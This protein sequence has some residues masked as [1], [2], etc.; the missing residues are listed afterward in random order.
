MSDPWDE[1][2][3]PKEAAVH[4]EAVQIAA[5]KTKDGFILKLAIHPSEVPES[6]MRDYVGSRYIV[7]MVKVND[8]QS[9]VMPPE[10]KKQDKVIT[11]AVM[12]CKNEKFWE[13]LNEVNS[14]QPTEPYRLDWADIEVKDEETAKKWVCL[15]CEVE[16]RSD[17]ADNN[18]ARDKF[19]GLV[20]DFEWWMKH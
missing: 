16:S 9:P 18:N 7:A 2:P 12:L 17:L 10:K 1:T 3:D 5:N 19:L 15:Y 4:F 13:Y 8:D 11:S 14:E 20:G 6:I